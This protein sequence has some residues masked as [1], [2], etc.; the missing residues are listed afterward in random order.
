MNPH[1]QPIKIGLGNQLFHHIVH[2]YPMYRQI[3]PTAWSRKRGLHGMDPLQVPL[4]ALCRY[5]AQ[6]FSLRPFSAGRF[7]AVVTT[8]TVAESPLRSAKTIFCL[9]GYLVF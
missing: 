1:G 5:G 2:G 8:R 9:I 3:Q 7:I 4:A 6:E